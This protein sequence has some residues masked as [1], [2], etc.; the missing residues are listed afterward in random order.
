MCESIRQIAS[1]V[2]LNLEIKKKQQQQRM[3]FQ[4]KSDNLGNIL[5]TLKFWLVELTVAVRW[6]T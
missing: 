5:F 3:V 6:S 2:I 4:T 1:S